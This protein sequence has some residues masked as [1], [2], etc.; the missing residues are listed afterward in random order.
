MEIVY[1]YFP[2]DGLC[3]RYIAVPSRIANKVMKPN[4]TILPH[5]EVLCPSCQEWWS[6]HVD[7]KNIDYESEPQHLLPP[8]R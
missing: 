2:C 4:G 6:W 1:R 8:P 3:G 5:D 7:Y